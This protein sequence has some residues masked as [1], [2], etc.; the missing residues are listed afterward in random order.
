MA[1]DPNSVTGLTTQIAMR[2]AK[3]IKPAKMT[4]SIPLI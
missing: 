3:Q 1:I 4:G 2:S